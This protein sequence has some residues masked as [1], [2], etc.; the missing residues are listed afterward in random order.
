VLSVSIWFYR[1]L[2][3]AW[4]LWLATALIRWLKWGWDQFG[5]GGLWKRSP[6]KAK[7]RDTV[8]PPPNA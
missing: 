4:A 7:A 5:A 2:M 8:P 3:L 1:L 6:K